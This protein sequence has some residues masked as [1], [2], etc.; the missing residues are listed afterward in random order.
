MRRYRAVPAVFFA[1][2]VSALVGGL[3]GRSALAVDDKIPDHYKAFT[4]ALDTIEN[5][6][7]GKNESDA[8]VYGAIRGMLGTLDQFSR[9]LDPDQ[10]REM[11]TNTGGQFGGL[12]IV[13][14]VVDQ[15]LTVKSVLPDSPAQLAGFAAG[16]QITEVD[17]DDTAGMTVDAL[18]ERLR[19]EVGTKVRVTLRRKG[20][21]KPQEV[22]VTRAVIRLQ[23]V[24]SRA[25]D[26]GVGYANYPDN[27]V[28]L[29]VREAAAAGQRRARRRPGRSADDP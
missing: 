27:V 26:N 5:K 9:L 3:F 23:S 6:Y 7:V 2:L 22:S 10:W 28:R 11:Q 4:T 19:G 13:V 8:L 17:G 20:W 24:E 16:D 12:G 21:P 15:V 14:Q 29:F 18:V 1:I 25:L